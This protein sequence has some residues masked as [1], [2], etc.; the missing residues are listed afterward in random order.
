MEQQRGASDVVPVD[1]TVLRS[2]PGVYTVIFPGLAVP[3]GTAH[4]YPYTGVAGC[5]A[6]D[7]SPMGTD[8][9]VDVVCEQRGT[10][11]DATYLINFSDSTS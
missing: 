6:V 7:L 8:E 9:H 10:L 2:G 11:T 3:H 1:A 5:A 4:A